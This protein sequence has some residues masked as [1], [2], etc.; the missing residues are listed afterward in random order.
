MDLLFPPDEEDAVVDSRLDRSVVAL[1]QDLIDDFPASD[2]RWMES[3]PGGGGSGVGASM[4]LLVLHQLTDK[5]TCHQYYDQFLRAVG[6]WA[7]LRGVTHRGGILDTA[8]LLAEHAEKTV[9]AVTLRTVHTEHQAVVDLAVRACLV[10]REVTVTGNLTD[11]DH[12]YREISRIDDIVSALVTVVRGSLRADSPREVA[13]AI[14]SANTVL[15]TVF[16]EVLT[17]RNKGLQQLVAGLI[18]SHM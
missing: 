11:Q 10:E 1:S 9:L 6:V 7:R 16:K 14:H 17:A 3:V 8:V 12:F 18:D 4:S 13:A 2:P 15:L 5:N